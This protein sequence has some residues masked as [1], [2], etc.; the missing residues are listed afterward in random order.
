M[1]LFRW[2]ASWAKMMSARGK[3]TTVACYPI[4]KVNKA[5]EITNIS[6]NNG[7]NIVST[8]KIIPF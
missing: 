5:E 1:T 4:K 8:L 7:L 3:L 6:T 2:Q